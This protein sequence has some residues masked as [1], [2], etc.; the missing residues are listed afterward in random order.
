MT[1][2][3]WTYAFAEGTEDDDTAELRLEP[4]DEPRL[5]TWAT[6]GSDQAVTVQRAAERPWSS[7]SEDFADFTVVDPGFDGRVS[8]TGN[9]PVAVAV[10]ELTDEAP[11]GYT[12]SGVTFRGDVAGRRLLGAA[13]GNSGQADLQVE[14]PLPSGRVVVPTLCAGGGKGTWTH[15]S[16]DGRE[17]SWGPGCSD[18]RFD[19]GAGGNEMPVRDPG[20]ATVRV[21]VTDGEDGPVVDDDDLVLGVGVYQP[22][23]DVATAAR[24]KVERLVERD[25]HVWRLVDT[26]DGEVGGRELVVP[27]HAGPETLVRVYFT[28]QRGIAHAVLNGRRTGAGFGGGTGST[29]AGIL[30]G[31]GTAGAI[32]TG[33]PGP[34]GQLGL[35]RYERVD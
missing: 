31:E 17:V 4:S 16:V 8:V 20:L 13:V 12:R 33:D 5:V 3:G 22:E 32:V 6:Q 18:D 30:Y 1:S 35:A 10:Y 14:V 2:L 11:E 34:R 25:G 19:P 28:N 7:T 23:P 15:L 29:Y 24:Q 21:W 27:A 26:T 9:G